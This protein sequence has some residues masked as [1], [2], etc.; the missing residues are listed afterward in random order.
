[1]APDKRPPRRIARSFCGDLSHRQAAQR[2]PLITQP[3]M[4]RALI[5]MQIVIS[6]LVRSLIANTGPPLVER[7]APPTKGRY[8]LPDRPCWDKRPGKESAAECLS[9]ANAGVRQV[10]RQAALTGQALGEICKVRR[11][12]ETAPTTLRVNRGQAPAS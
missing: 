9:N 6:W 10:K 8:F 12:A 11:V 1:M 4:A 5:S 7:R 2:V 3:T